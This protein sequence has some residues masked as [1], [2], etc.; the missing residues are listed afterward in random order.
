M[1]ATNENV[2][3]TV[4]KDFYRYIDE[5]QSD[6]I[7]QL[8]GNG[9]IDHDAQDKK[10]GLEELQGLIV[11]LHQGFDG[12]SH[13]LEQVYL[14]DRDKI[15]VRW[16]MTGKHTGSF[17]NTPSS[18][19]DIIVYGHDLFKIAEGKIVEQWHIE[20]LLSLMTQIKEKK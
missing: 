20:Q 17:F 3:I 9:F 8:I 13:E 15:F 6:K 10:N 19:K 2:M 16:K 14:V 11:A 12:I 7:S 1:K 18:G 5:N 4:V